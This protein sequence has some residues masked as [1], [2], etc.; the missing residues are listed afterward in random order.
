MPEQPI[1]QQRL[2][3]EERSAQGKSLRKQVPRSSHGEWTPASDRPN[4]LQL[5]QAQDEGRLDHLL[6]IKYGRLVASPFVFLR[7]SAVVMASDLANTPVTGLDAATCGDA[8][9]SNFG[10]FAT[11][12]RNLVFDLNDF[13]E[14]F[15]GPWEWDIKRLAASAVVAGRQNGFK[16]KDNLKLAQLVTRVYRK[17]MNRFSKLPILDVWYFHVETDKILAQIENYSKEAGKRTGK[18]LKKARKK[19]QA[20]TLEKL[21]QLVDGKRQFINNPPLLVRLSDLLTEEQKSQVKEQDIEKAWFEYLNSLPRERRVLLSR[22]RIADGALRVGG[23]GSVGTR[24]SILLLEG[25]APQDAIILKQ[26]EVGPSVLEAYL[27]KRDYSSYAQRVVTG[28][29]MMKAASDI[30]LG[31]HQNPTT[32]RH[33]YWRQ[34]KDMKGSVDV[35]TLDERGLGAYLAVCSLCLARAHGRTGDPVA[36]TG[37][38]GK[39]DVFDQAIGKFAVPYAD[40]TEQDYQLLVDAVNSG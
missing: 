6:P 8:H 32:T 21:T 27:P 12:E 33:F 34:L 24:C 31:W 23:V 9:L 16:E 5:L 7:G 15:I 10:V 22:F 20:R 39:G 38:L 13:D 18:V 4:P 35:S 29:R 26:K 30:F 3:V 36:I 28:Q 25:S 17:A 40:Q 37:Y 14:V 11:P 1:D 2:S 19:T